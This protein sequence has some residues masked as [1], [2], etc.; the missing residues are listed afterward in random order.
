MTGFVE[1]CNCKGQSHAR[2]LGSV[3]SGGNRDRTLHSLQVRITV[4]K[5]APVIELFPLQIIYSCAFVYFEK[6]LLYERYS[7]GVTVFETAC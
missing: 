6:D 2:P 1:T 7:L 5:S 4:C 3:S